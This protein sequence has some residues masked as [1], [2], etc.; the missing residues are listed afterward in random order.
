MIE[1]TEVVLARALTPFPV[2]VRTL[3]A[4][5]L[6]TA[7]FLRAQGESVELASYDNRLVAAARAMSIPLAT[8]TP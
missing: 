5:H 2:A 7:E 1:T 3:D 4:L 8:L 6:A